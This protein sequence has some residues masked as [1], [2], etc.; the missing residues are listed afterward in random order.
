MIATHAAT[1]EDASLIVERIHKANSVR[2]D[3][4][5]KEKMQNFCD[6]LLRRFI[7]IGEGF[8]KGG[9]GGV[10]LGRHAQLDSLIEVLYL[11]AQDSPDSAGAVWGRRLG[12]FQ[13]AHSKRIRDSE[14]VPQDDNEYSAWPSTGTL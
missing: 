13:N 11:M 6:V 9:D 3:K 12:I 14:M 10:E 2:L 5:N 7:G 8:Y 4:R 1:G